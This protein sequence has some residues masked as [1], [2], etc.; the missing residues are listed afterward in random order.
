MRQQKTVGLVGVGLMGHGIALN[1]LRG[2]YP[3]CFLAHAGNQ[4]TD[5]LVGATAHTSLE[6]LCAQADIII[7]CVTGSAQVREIVL[8]EG[9]LIEHL[10]AGKTL[11]DCST[12]Q[13]DETRAIATAVLASGAAFLDAPMTRTPKEAAEGRLNLLVGGATNT[14][15]AHRALLNCF[16]ENIT[17][18]GQTPGDGHAAKLLHNFVSLGFAALL[19]EAYAAARKSGLD[20]EALTAVLEAGGGKSVALARMA[21]YAVGGDASSLQFSIAN[22][23]KD[24]GYY[25]DYAREIGA[26]AQIARAVAALYASASDGG[27]GGKMVPEL[28]TLLGEGTQ[29]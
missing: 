28:I 8:G 23:A 21:P 27:K 20:S 29:H 24:T 22:A 25:A 17:H 7:L 4:P 16:A 12:S 6:A 1:I 10:S 5:D 18:V 13:P 15:D 11:I 26:S 9:G 3:L 14:L 19:G 2:G